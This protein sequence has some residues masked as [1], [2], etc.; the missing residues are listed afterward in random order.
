MEVVPSDYE[1]LV[2][3]NNGILAIWRDAADSAV[4]SVGVLFLQ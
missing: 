3:W 1:I 2:E 4:Q